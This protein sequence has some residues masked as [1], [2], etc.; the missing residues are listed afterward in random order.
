MGFFVT[1]SK[2]ESQPYHNSIFRSS[3]EHKESGQKTTANHLPPQ[4][5]PQSAWNHRQEV[6]LLLIPLKFEDRTKKIIAINLTGLRRANMYICMC[7]YFHGK[8]KLAVFLMENSMPFGLRIL[9]EQTQPE[10]RIPGSVTFCLSC[11]AIFYPG[12]SFLQEYPSFP[13]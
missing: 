11:K 12:I 3:T 5:F 7:I 2:F 13:G 1:G 8:I 10:Y 6:P 9:Q 4:I